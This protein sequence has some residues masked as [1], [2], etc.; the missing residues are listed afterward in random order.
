MLRTGF[1]AAS[2]KWKDLANVLCDASMPK[3]LKGKIYKPMIRPVLM[4]GA[5][6]WIVTRRREGYWREQK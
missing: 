3:Y 2:Q 4:Y 5:E 6:T 1:K